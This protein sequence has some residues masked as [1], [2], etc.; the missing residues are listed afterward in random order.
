MGPVTTAAWLLALS[1]HGHLQQ[2]PRPTPSP[3]CPRHP[4]A[5][6]KEEFK[7][8]KEFV[9]AAYAMDPRVVAKKENDRLEK[10]V[11]LGG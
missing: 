5:G 3:R 4:P 9:N 6:K 1:P 7:R 8:L 10:W 11:G 2:S